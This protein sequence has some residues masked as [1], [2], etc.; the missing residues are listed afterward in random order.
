MSIIDYTQIA[1][2]TPITANVFNER[3]GQIVNV[4]N[5]GIDQTNIKKQSLGRD[6]FTSDAMQAAWPIGSVYISVSPTNPGPQLGGNW[7]AFARGRTLVGVDDTQTEFNA[8][9]K[10]GGHKSLQVHSHTGTTSTDGNHVHG[11]ARDGVVTSGSG[12][13]RTIRSGN[14]QQLAWNGQLVMHGAGNHSHSF[15]TSNAGSGNAGN[16]Q[17]YITVYF[18]QRI[19]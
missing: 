9:E 16:L 11:F 14:G 6:A 19:S 8:V 18:W 3:Y 2:N 7:V 1:D 12:V 13:E 10:V 17:P 15:T 5:G 4:I